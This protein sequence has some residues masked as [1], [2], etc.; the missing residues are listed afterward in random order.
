MNSLRFRRHTGNFRTTAAT[1]TTLRFY[2]CMIMILS[3]KALRRRLEVHRT[4]SLS[5]LRRLAP[6]LA[7]RRQG[8]VDSNRHGDLK[9]PNYPSRQSLA[10]IMMTH[11]DI[12]SPTGFSPYPISGFYP[13]SPAGHRDVQVWTR[14]SESRYR[15][16]LLTY[17]ARAGKC[18]ILVC[19][20]I[21]PYISFTSMI[22]KLEIIIMMISTTSNR[23]S[24]WHTVTGMT[25]S[26]AKSADKKQYRCCFLSMV[27]VGRALGSEG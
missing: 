9:Y 20:D 18:R 3:S 7:G 1:G 5:L 21:G 13:I 2:N 11:H 12:P 6:R 10:R 19:P 16:L 8:R 24:P 14:V 4:G 22:P 15:V 27:R 17:R 26:S 25:L 23:D